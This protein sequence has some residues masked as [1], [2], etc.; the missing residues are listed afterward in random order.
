M[1]RSRLNRAA[2]IP[3]HNNS[4]AYR[5]SFSYGLR[6]VNSLRKFLARACILRGRARENLNSMFKNG[7]SYE[8]SPGPR[9]GYTRVEE[10]GREGRRGVGRREVDDG[11]ARERERE[12]E[13][14]K[15]RK[16]ERCNLLFRNKL[17]HG[18][19]VS[20]YYTRLQRVVNDFNEESVSC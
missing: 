10:T 18:K 5:A 8:A 1:A 2:D 15:E 4:R 13:R 12:E 3:G 6:A 11:K 14:E 17:R 16:R 20:A 9:R 19:N 7:I